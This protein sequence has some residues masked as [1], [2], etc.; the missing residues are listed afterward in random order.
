MGLVERATGGCRGGAGGGRAHLVGGDAARSG[1]E[2]DASG[3][4]EDGVELGDPDECLRVCVPRIHDNQIA[5]GEILDV[6]GRQCRAVNA[7]NGSDL[8]IQFANRSA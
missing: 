2:E 4:G 6:S 1:S 5:V 7:G 3:G 8:R